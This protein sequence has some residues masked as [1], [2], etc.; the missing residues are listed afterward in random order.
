MYSVNKEL[1]E[2][3]LREILISDDPKP[4]KVVLK[5]D[6]LSEYFPDEMP[7][8]TIEEFIIRLLDEWKEKGG[9]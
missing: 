4:V 8:E 3:L 7:A 9:Q 5:A 6:I 2:A 1:T